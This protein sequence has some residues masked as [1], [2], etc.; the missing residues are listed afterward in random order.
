MK[1]NGLQSWPVVTALTWLE[2]ALFLGVVGG[3]GSK[4]R[5]HLPATARLHRLMGG[6]GPEFV[7]LANGHG[8]R[9]DGHDDSDQRADVCGLHKMS[10]Q[11]VR[12]LFKQV[13]MDTKH[14]FHAHDGA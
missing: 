11:F 7:V 14:W 12:A 5:H 3:G 1:I 9:D 4:K 10:F 13:E 8:N 6:K 2:L